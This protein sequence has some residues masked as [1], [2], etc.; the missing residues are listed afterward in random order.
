MIGTNQPFKKYIYNKFPSLPENIKIIEPQVIINSWSILSISTVTLVHTST[1]G[2]ES[3]LVGKPCVVV[4][5]TNYRDK[6]FTYDVKSK[7]E[8]FKAILEYEKL[9]LNIE[10]YKELAKRY[11]YLFFIRYQIPSQFFI[12]NKSDVAYLYNF[13]STKELLENKSLNLIIDSIENT[14]DI[15]LDN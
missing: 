6:G 14:N 1:V 12:S 13:N 10:K 5:K 11:A 2:L 8:Y 4:S 7:E 3:V 9:F 15:F